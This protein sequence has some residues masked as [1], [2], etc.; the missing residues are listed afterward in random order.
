MSQPH[1]QHSGTHS[2]LPPSYSTPGQPP[3]G[4]AQSGSVPPQGPVPPPEPKKRSW[5]ARHKILTALLVVVALVIAIKAFS[6]GSDSAPD[7]EPAADQS[8]AE[9]ADSGDSA[10]GAAGDQDEEVEPAGRDNSTAEQT[11]LGAGTFT[12]GEDVP[13]GRYVIEPGA[14]QSGNL[15]ASSE[16]DPLAINEILGGEVGFG[17][18]SVTSTLTDGEQLEISGLSEVTFTPAETELRSTLSAGDWVVGLDIAAG[19]YVAT[20]ADG[21]SGNF[22]VYDDWGLPATNEILGEDD[23][24][25]VPEVTVSL[26]DGD[27]IEISGLSEVTFTEK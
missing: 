7:A 27:E 8:A 4:A 16:E 9:A 12:V 22:V 5:F 26:A 18:P 23:G 19:D 1:Q 21:E 6:G 11:T 10:A 17:V 24:F 2:Q 3:A 25:S 13:P 15:S 20:P 14:G